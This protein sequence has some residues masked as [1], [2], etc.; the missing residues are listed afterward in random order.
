MYVGFVRFKPTISFQPLLPYRTQKGIFLQTREY[1]Y[2]GKFQE[3]QIWY[4]EPW[5]ITQKQFTWTDLGSYFIL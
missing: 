4:G 1:N 5:T 2:I 3:I